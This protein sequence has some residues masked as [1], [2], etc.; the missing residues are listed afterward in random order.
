ME[1]IVELVAYV[2]SLTELDKLNLSQLIRFKEPE[3]LKALIMEAEVVSN[4]E[5][6]K[7][8]LVAYL[9]RLLNHTPS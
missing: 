6:A 4:P 9:L 1:T 8:C 2:E 3:D 7:F 5:A